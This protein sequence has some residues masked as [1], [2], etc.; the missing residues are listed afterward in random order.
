MRVAHHTTTPFG[1]RARGDAGVRGQDCDGKHEFVQDPAETEG[2]VVD[3][4]VHGRMVG[5]DTRGIL[6]FPL[7]SAVVSADTV[8]MENKPETPMRLPDDRKTGH[9]S[10]PR[11]PCVTGCGEMLTTPAEICDACA[12][13]YADEWCQRQAEDLAC[14]GWR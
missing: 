8:G 4:V 1:D 10:V 5:Q 12:Q 14:G 2:V 7:D 13:D 11:H 3:V 6:S 9:W